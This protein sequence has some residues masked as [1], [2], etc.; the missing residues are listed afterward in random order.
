MDE[1]PPPRLVRL[2]RLND[3]VLGVPEVVPGVPPR[4]GVAAPDPAARQAL[5][6]VD[7][8]QALGEAVEALAWLVHH[9]PWVG[10]Q[11]GALVRSSTVLPGERRPE[12][13]ARA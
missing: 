5:P 2:G 11:V 6:E 1:A 8:P 12:L 7:P 9:D 13:L 4:R 3:R 10:K